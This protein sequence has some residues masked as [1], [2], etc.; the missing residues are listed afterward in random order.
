MHRVNPS[1]Q[2]RIYE[3]F[4]SFLIWPYYSER[5]PVICRS[6]VNGAASLPVHFL[7]FTG[8]AACDYALP[9]LSGL[10]GGGSVL[11]HR[12]SGSCCFCALGK[13]GSLVY[14]LVLS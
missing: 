5:Q 4:Q 6:P 12:D 13:G 14:C 8:R 11:C 2:R 1:Q 3:Q 10:P 7:S 9:A